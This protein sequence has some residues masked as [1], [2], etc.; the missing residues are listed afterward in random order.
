MKI[1]G[2]DIGGA[3]TDLAVVDFDESGNIKGIKTDFKYLPMWMKKDELKEALIELLGSEVDEVDAVAVSMTA[4]LVDAYKT[5]KEGVLDIATKSDETFTVPVGFVGLNGIMDLEGI[6]QDPLRAAAANWVATAPIAAKLSP[7]C[8]MIDTGSTTTDIIPI[9]NGKEC[10]KGRSDLERLKTG[11]LIYTGTLRTNVAALVDK[12]PLDGE[13]VRVAS[14]LFAVTAD[15]HMVLENIEESDYI[16]STPDG[17][18]K[19]PEECMRRI[20]RVICGDMD[21]LTRENI[22]EIAGYVHEAQVA[23]VADALLEVS[24]RNSIDTVVTTGLGMNIIC[25]KACEA[26]GLK[27][28]GMDEVIS[29][30]DCVVAPAVGTAIL[31]E[32]YLRNE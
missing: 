14:E 8:I 24:N 23:R 6:K 25:K 5:K 27:S 21:V 32:E 3:N 26:A 2:F 4:E 11:E 28:M 12:V 31:M 7:D 18:G 1:A 13:W 15:I 16:C 10:S 29:S 20:S 30:E 19:S 17:A 22:K 9:K